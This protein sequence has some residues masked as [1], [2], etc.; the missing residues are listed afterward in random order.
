MLNLFGLKIRNCCFV[1][2]LSFLTLL[3]RPRESGDPDAVLMKMGNY[4][5]WIPAFAG[6]IGAG[7]DKGRIRNSAIVYLK[8][9][10]QNNKL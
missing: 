7:D 2:I 10:L 5:D 6:T 4:K 8:N 1:P 3:C 9:P